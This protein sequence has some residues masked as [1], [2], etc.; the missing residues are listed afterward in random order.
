M[1]YVL[2]IRNQCVSSWK[3]IILVLVSPHF[4]LWYLWEIIRI[5]HSQ[6]YTM[7][8]Y[9]LMI[10]QIKGP[11]PFVSG[12]LLDIELMDPLNKINNGIKN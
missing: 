5:E 11:C 10:D 8:K 4:C 2:W 1:S 3:V 6:S 9:W 12:G 7:G